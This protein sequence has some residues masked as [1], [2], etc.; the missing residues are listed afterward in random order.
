MSEAEEIR[1]VPGAKRAEGDLPETLGIVVTAIED[2]KGSGVLIVDVREIA[3]FTDYM[4]MCTGGS[5]R[6]VQAI[7][8]GVKEKLREINETPLHTEGYEQAAWVLVDYFDFIVNVFTPEAR[9]HYQLERVWR[10]APLL[11]GERAERPTGDG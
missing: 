4:I 3:S 9:E 2:H 6:H 11:L 7:V 8:D 5:D 1:A 10:D